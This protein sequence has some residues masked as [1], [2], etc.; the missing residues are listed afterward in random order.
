MIQISTVESRQTVKTVCQGKCLQKYS[1]EG[2][3]LLKGP[4][5]RAFLMRSS[6]VYI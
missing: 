1:R 3:T 2:V 6:L 4:L 5:G